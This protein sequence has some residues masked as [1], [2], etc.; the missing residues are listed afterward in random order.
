M[1]IDES[2]LREVSLCA[3]GQIF[4]GNLCDKLLE[5]RVAVPFQ[6]NAVIYEAGDQERTFFFIRAGCVKAGTL[7]DDG[8]EIIYL[9]RKSGDVVGELSACR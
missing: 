8:H 3:L 2:V 1:S 9:I 4:R 5:N 6:R 7:A